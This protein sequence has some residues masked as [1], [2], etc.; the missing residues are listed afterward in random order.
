MTQLDLQLVSLVVV[1]ACFIIVAGVAA[2]WLA[3]VAL[4]KYARYELDA[5][6]RALKMQTLI[7]ERVN[8]RLATIPVA[9]LGEAVSSAGEGPIPAQPPDPGVHTRSIVDDV[10]ELEREMGRVINPDAE[11]DKRDLFEQP[12][13]PV[14]I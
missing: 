8:A 6:E 13:Q 14:E 11:Y 10:H 4:V 2:I 3:I 7:N 1:L 12:L 9:K 5:G